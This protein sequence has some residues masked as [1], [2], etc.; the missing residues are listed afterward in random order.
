MKLAGMIINI[1]RLLTRKNDLMAFITIEDLVDSIEC[2]VFPRTFEQ[3]LEYI[4]EDKVVTVIGKLQ[5]S[6]AEETKLIV[7]RITPIEEEMKKNN[8]RKLF[9]RMDSKDD[10][11]TINE[12][13][14][15]L[16]AFKGNTDV[17]FYFSNEKLTTANEKIKIDVARIEDITTS[18]SQHLEEKDIVLR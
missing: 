8:G 6:D 12:I 3:Y 4:E 16:S 11:N 14:N 5:V 10:T 15:V 9:L 2:V 17:V 7:E 18:L 1:R 13:I